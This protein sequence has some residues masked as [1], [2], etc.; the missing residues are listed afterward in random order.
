MD[1]VWFD[2]HSDCSF[3]NDHPV[4]GIHMKRVLVKV[5]GETWTA[6]G[7]LRGG[8][9]SHKL[10]CGVVLLVDHPAIYARFVEVFGWDWAQNQ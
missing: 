9:V 2:C 1:T 7:S 4:G 3:L 6:L 5:G 8:E 10:N